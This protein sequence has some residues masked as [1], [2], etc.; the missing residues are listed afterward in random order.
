MES[1]GF[2]DADGAELFLGDVVRARIEEPF[3]ELHGT[4]GEY[5]ITKAAGGYVLSYSRSE[6]GCILPF[7]YTA[8]FMTEFCPDSIPDLKILLWSKTPPKHP[9]LHKVDD[10]M[11]GDQRRDLF[12]VESRERRRAREKTN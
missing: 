1:T 10:G 12:S 9:R 6:K 3:Q 2:A 5:E 8:C 4:W 11:T 7:G